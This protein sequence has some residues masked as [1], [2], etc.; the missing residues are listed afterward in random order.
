MG[1]AGGAA[2]GTPATG[3]TCAGGKG[4]WLAGGGAAGGAKGD[5]GGVAV[6]R[7]AAAAPVEPPAGVVRSGLL[8]GADTAAVVGRGSPVGASVGRN[9]ASGVLLAFVGVVGQGRPA[10]R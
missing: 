9:A 10:A 8:T 1:A 5:A 4:V 7:G 2:S 6:C 3:G